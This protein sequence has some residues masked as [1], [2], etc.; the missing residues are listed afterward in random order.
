MLHADMLRRA[1][2]VLLVSTRRLN[3][4]KAARTTIAFAETRMIDMMHQEQLRRTFELARAKLLAEQDAKLLW[5]LQ[6]YNS[7]KMV[8][9]LGLQTFAMTDMIERERF[10]KEAVVLRTVVVEGSTPMEEV[11]VVEENYEDNVAET[12][13]FHENKEYTPEED[14]FIIDIYNQYAFQRDA[15]NNILMN[16]DNEPMTVRSRYKII[17]DKLEEVSQGK[18]K[19][20]LNGVKQQIYKLKQRQSNGEFPENFPRIL[21]V[22]ES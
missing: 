3:Q 9:D 12:R 4:T 2:E 8:K 6:N 19:R 7:E 15:Q 13:T 21:F 16:S 10:H 14:A 11:A 22:P 1:E 5:D 17:V 18:Y 20:G